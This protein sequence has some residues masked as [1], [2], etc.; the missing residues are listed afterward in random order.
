M[1]N[2]PLQQQVTKNHLLRNLSEVKNHLGKNC[3]FL[4]FS[5]ESSLNPETGQ[6]EEYNAFNAVM[7]NNLGGKDRVI[8]RIDKTL[9]ALDNEDFMML[10]NSLNTMSYEG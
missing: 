4:A 6:V 7:L 10:A 3:T 2:K 5:K 8:Y 9:D 1:K